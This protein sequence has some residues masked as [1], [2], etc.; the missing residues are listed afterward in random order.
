[1]YNNPLRRLPDLK[2]K[3]FLIEHFLFNLIL[4][5]SEGVRTGAALPSLG[6]TGG[7]IAGGEEVGDGC[8]GLLSIRG[9]TGGGVLAGL[10][11]VTFAGVPGD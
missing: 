8:D 11:L 3:I 6:G 4:L 5:S 9:G 2:H 1:M 10:G 7:G